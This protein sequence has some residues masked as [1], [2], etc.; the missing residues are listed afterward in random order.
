MPASVLVPAAILVGTKLYEAGQNN[1]AAKEQGRQFD[2]SIAFEREKEA[3]RREEFDR[4]QALAKQQYDE[5]EARLAPFR[6]AAAGALAARA[7]RLGISLSPASIEGLTKQYIPSRLTPTGD[8]VDTPTR[9]ASRT[10]PTTLSSFGTGDYG[11]M[12]PP[13]TAPRA[14]SLDDILGYRA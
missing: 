3:R 9:T 8:T 7:K 12:T 2:Q 1:K 13:L 11:V 6:A 5:Q 10:A 14:M 4:Q